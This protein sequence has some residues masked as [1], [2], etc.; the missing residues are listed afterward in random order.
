M[1]KSKQI[2]TTLSSLKRLERMGTEDSK[3]VLKLKEAC[4]FIAGQIGSAIRGDLILGDYTIKEGKMYL[5]GKEITTANIT[6]LEAVQF[7][8]DIAHSLI[9]NIRNYLESN[10]IDYDKTAPVFHKK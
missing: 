6:I 2:V 1:D 8:L 10:N 5:N 9:D 4:E 3:P 7:S